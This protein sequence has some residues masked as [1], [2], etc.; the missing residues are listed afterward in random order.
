[1]KYFV[2]TDDELQFYG[3][4]T[5]YV[6]EHTKRDRPY[7]DIQTLKEFAAKCQ[8]IEL[9][10]R[11]I[12]WYKGWDVKDLPVYELEQKIKDEQKQLIDM[13]KKDFVELKSRFSETIKPFVFPDKVLKCSYAY[14][15]EWNDILVVMEDEDKYFGIY[16]STEA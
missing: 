10:D 5:I 9:K 1:M 16:Y 4:E 2:L 13:P 15:P 8:F 6:F 7:K 14:E 12:Y 11:H 3:Q